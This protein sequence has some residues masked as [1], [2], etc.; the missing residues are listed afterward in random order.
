MIVVDG[1]E[2]YKKVKLSKI[3]YVEEYHCP[4]IIKIMSDPEKGTVSAFCLEA[5]INEDKFYKWLKDFPIFKECYGIAKA[6]SKE[7]WEKL[8]KEICEEVGIPGTQNH[9]FEY[10]RMVGWS[11]FGIGKNSRVRLDLD[12]KKSPNEHYS[13]LIEQARN[14]D[15][16]AGE[17]KQLMEAINVGMNAHQVFTLQKEIDGLKSD[18]QLMNENNKAYG[19]NSRADQRIEKKD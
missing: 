5:M 2:I 3:H 6:F 19:N 8:G 4:L 16:T 7:N 14:G 1:Q 15:F 13:E 17:I 10:W 18:L 12:S 9:R 11:R